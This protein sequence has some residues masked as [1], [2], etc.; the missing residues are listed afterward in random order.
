QALRHVTLAL[1]QEPDNGAYLDTLGWIYFKK[2]DYAAAINPLARALKREGDSP[3]I[4]DHLGDA[5]AAQK[6]QRKAVS[7]W[8]RSLKQDPANKAV[9]EKLVQSGV[10]P[11][12]LPFLKKTPGQGAAGR[13]PF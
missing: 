7:F 6:D 2:G 13:F 11:G 4:L 3:T 1:K 9:R 8:R 10:D 12:V 5:W